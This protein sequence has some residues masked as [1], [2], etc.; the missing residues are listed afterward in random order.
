VKSISICLRGHLL[1][2]DLIL[3]YGSILVM[4]WVVFPVAGFLLTAMP[5]IN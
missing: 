3:G 4:Q 5:W 1:E 2:A